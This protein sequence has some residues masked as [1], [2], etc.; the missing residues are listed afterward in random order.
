[1]TDPVDRLRTIALTLP[2]VTG[3]LLD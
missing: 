1:M 2:E 3:K